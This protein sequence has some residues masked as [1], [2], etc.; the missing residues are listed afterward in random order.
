M[1][2]LSPTKSFED[3]VNRIND[4]ITIRPKT[5]TVNP[6][7]ETILL[8]HGHA[9]DNVFILLHG[10]T[11]SPQQ[12]RLLGNQLH[13]Q[14][15]NVLIPRMPHHGLNDR[16]TDSLKQLS[17]R[18]LTDYANTVVDA[19]IG[20]GTRITTLG[21]SAGGVLSSYMGA[22]RPEI[23]RSVIISPAFALHMLPPALNGFAVK[24]IRTLPNR[25]VWWGEPGEMGDSQLYAYPRMSTHGLAGIMQVGQSVVQAARRRPP[26]I[27]QAIF[28]L[29]DSDESVHQGA[30]R[31]LSRL[32]QKKGVDVQS[33][34]FARTHA[35]DH[36]L[37]DPQHPMQ[38]TP[39]V[40]GKLF[41]L[42]SA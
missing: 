7:S 8:H 1:K 39:L 5:G 11:S 29:N 33:Y 32:W 6:V 41:E 27:T 17:A 34:T 38:N 12:F 23:S 4:G 21:L 35:L 18:T 2:T 13:Q 40:Y 31:M 25:N 3:A 30:A 28:V 22:F 15:H 37:I 26:A 10:Y 14:G 9:T 36:D 16:L 24:L 42:L 20:L 19:A